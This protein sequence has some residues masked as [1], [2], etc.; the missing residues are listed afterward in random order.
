MRKY[1]AAVSQLVDMNESEMGWLANHMGHNIHVHKEF[2]RLP[3]TTIE[4]AIVGNLLMAVDEGRAHLF[5]G[6]NPRQLHLSDFDTAPQEDACKG[7]STGNL[8]ENENSD[9]DGEPSQGA[10]TTKKQTNV[11]KKRKGSIPKQ[12][13]TD[14]KKIVHKYFSEHIKRNRLPKKGECVDFVE[15]NKEIIKGR[16][17][18]TVKDY[19]RNYLEKKKRC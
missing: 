3:Q 2:Y 10:D 4:M 9:E 6:K 8:A 7:S 5:K 15:G 17:W 18:S 1:V 13:T 11:L 19:V 14:E 12:W 16:Q